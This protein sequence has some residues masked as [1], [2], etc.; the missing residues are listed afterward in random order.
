MRTLR[1]LFLPVLAALVIEAQITPAQEAPWTAFTTDNNEFS[2]AVPPETILINEVK[3]YPKFVLS[4]QE[5][6]L[7]ISIV[8]N[9]GPSDSALA[10]RPAAR[11][12]GMETEFELGKVVGQVIVSENPE[13]YATVIYASSKK[14]SYTIAAYARERDHPRVR[15]FLASLKFGGTPLMNIQGITY[16]IPPNPQKL[17]EMP[18][19][20]IVKQFLKMPVNKKSEIRFEPIPADLMI[21]VAGER[22]AAI[23]LTKVTR[24][25]IILRNPKPAYRP[26]VRSG[27]GTVAVDVTLLAN[28][29]VGTIIVDPRPDRGM[30]E[31]AAEAA[32]QIKFIPEEIEGKPVDVRRRFVYGYTS[33]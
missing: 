19:S 10:L 8:P 23:D 6:R 7:D 31:S 4:S 3:D 25:L 30:A 22:D 11:N 12:R 33:Y 20:P 24:S 32:R 26:S 13:R 21:P 14:F 16:D 18:S 17:E 28:G 27:R 2:A 29:Q 5:V 15:K 1:H 9:R